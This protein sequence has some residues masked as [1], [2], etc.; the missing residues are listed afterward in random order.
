M[1]TTMDRWGY[2]LPLLPHNQKSREQTQVADSLSTMLMLTI[3][4][5]IQLARTRALK[6]TVNPWTKEH[7]T[8]FK[9]KSIT[10][11]ISDVDLEKP[12]S[13][14]V[15]AVEVAPIG[16]YFL[17]TIPSLSNSIFVFI[18]LDPIKD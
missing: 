4:T 10:R 15:Q 12:R 3:T 18:R 2:H 6:R 1:W 9:Q 11:G 5:L 13:A 14:K 8:Y 17:Q 16:R 7:K